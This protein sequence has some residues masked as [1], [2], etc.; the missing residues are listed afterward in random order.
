MAKRNNP[1]VS[2]R[3]TAL[4]AVSVAEYW[5]RYFGNRRFP[6]NQEYYVVY[7]SLDQA[8]PFQPESASRYWLI[9]FSFLPTALRLG[10]TVPDER[11]QAIRAAY[12][13]IV[14]EGVS[15]FRKAPTIMPHFS[16]SDSSAARAA[17]TLLKPINCCPSLHTASPLFL[18]N[19]G[20]EYLP[21]AEPALRKHIGDIVSTVIKAKFHAI[22]DV[23]FGMLLTRRILENSL[24]L[25][26]RSLETFFIEEQ[27]K[28]DQVPYE[29]IFRMYREIYELEKTMGGEETTLAKIMERYFQEIGLPCVRR[30]ASACYYDL[31]RKTL[32]YPSE[33]R[34]GK[35]LL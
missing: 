20:A 33:L 6:A 5:Q 29:H 10:N 8:V 23:A 18:Y 19:L 13:E 35:G 32:A 9:N 15:A 3:N 1:I 31:D 25:E 27:G 26:F 12:R 24:G 16:L 4:L 14:K 22:I 34:V 28:Q 7:T 17:R 30:Q 21:G 11:F 2:V